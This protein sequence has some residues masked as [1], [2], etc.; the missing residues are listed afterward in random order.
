M[1][2]E[3]AEIVVI[4]ATVIADHFNVSSNAFISS[5]ISTN[6]DDPKL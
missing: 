2:M 3:A 1:F 5:L 4:G 6:Y